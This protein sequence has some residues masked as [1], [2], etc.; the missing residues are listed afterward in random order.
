MKT[1]ENM[2]IKIFLQKLLYEELEEDYVIKYLKHNYAKGITPVELAEVVKVLREYSLHFKNQVQESIDTCG[3]G[4]DGK[5]SLNVSSAVAV[6]LASIGIHVVKHGNHSHSSLLGSADIFK[7]LNVPID[8]TGF[9]AEEF[10]NKHNFIF[11]YAPLYQPAMSKV[12]KIRQKIDSPTIFNLVGPL[13]NPGRPNYQIIGVS[14]RKN[15]KLYVET[16]K[17]L[18]WGQ[19][20]VYT[21]ADSFDEVSTFA[22]TEC[23][24]IKNGKSRV[25]YIKPEEFFEPF[26]MPV[27]KSVSESYN[28]FL[29]VFRGVEEKFINLVAINASL[30]LHLVENINLKEAFLICKEELVSG[31]AYKK[32]LSLKNYKVKEV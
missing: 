24:E 2:E 4:G 29:D 17:L 3:T 30:G 20:I 25:F 28:A 32:L 12:K 10:Y 26:A 21:S 1:Y 22:P 11:L 27:I 16:L 8:L 5:C 23:I 7:L 31:R 6:V 18:D 13:L 14:N 15:L 19:Y 9:I